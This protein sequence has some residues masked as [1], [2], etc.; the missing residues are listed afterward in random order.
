ML[1]ANPIQVNDCID[2]GGNSVNGKPPVF[3]FKNS[4][5]CLLELPKLMRLSL[6]THT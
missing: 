3:L 1:T 2:A 6:L 4:E 5:N